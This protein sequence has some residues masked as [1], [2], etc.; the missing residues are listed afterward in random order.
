VIVTDRFV[1]LHLH[2]SGGSFVNRFLLQWMPDAR[3]IGYHLPRAY[4]PAEARHLPILGSVRNP[5]DYYVSW[6]SF[7]Q[8]MPSPNALF[9]VASDN[10]RLGFAGTIGNLLRMGEDADLFADWQRR[11]PVQLP[12]RGINLSQACVAPLAGS[13]MGFYSFLYRRMYGDLTQTT[14]IDMPRLRAG[15]ILFLDDVGVPVSEAMSAWLRDSAPVNAS[16][17]AHYS[18]HYDDALRELVARKDADIIQGH[19]YRFSTEPVAPGA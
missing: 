8:A 10:R 17:H 12:N 6:Y 16:A 15:L 4:I 18:H 7:Q 3:A 9:L 2:K 19:G 13:G 1:F 5:W 11:L 14:L